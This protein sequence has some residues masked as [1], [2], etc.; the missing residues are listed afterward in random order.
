MR[1]YL[2]I[3]IVVALSSCQ[4]WTAR[5]EKKYQVSERKYELTMFSGGQVVFKDSVKT[6]VNSEDN[7]D[8]IYYY[9]GD[10]LVEVSGDYV[11]KSIN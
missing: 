7:S 5:V 11:L 3:L 2:I 6:I 10:T 9:K 1:K 8:G 4:R